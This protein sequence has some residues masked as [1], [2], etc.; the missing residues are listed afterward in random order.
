MAGKPLPVWVNGVCFI[1]VKDAAEEASRLS[2][3]KVSA[4][5][6]SRQL[7]RAGAA[8]VGG[9]TL[10]ASP[11]EGKPGAETPGGA[12]T[13]AGPRP[14]LRYPPGERPLDRGVCRAGR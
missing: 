13:P 8:A 1:G 14:L 6:V 9:V 7:R 12:G 10:G 3:R 2:G 5:W 11:P 4:I